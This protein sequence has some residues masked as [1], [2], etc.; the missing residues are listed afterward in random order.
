M[1]N[2]ALYLVTDSRPEILGDRDLCTVVEE[3]LKGGRSH[4]RLLPSIEGIRPVLTDLVLLQVLL[5]SS[6]VISIATAAASLRRLRNCTT[7]QRPTTCRSSSMIAS[8]LPWL[9]ELRESIS[10]RMI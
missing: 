10:A 3:A 8:M 9:L 7:L 2:L 1:A 6:T 4:L 5:L